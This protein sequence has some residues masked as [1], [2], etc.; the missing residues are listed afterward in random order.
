MNEKMKR[1]ARAGNNVAVLRMAY[2]FFSLGLQLCILFYA[3][4]RL[5]EY[6]IYFYA[7]CSGI[8]LVLSLFIV[9]NRSNPGYK[10]AWI[11]IVLTLPIFGIL[12]YLLFGK[13]YA[14]RRVQR[15][16][17]RAKNQVREALEQDCAQREGLLAENPEAE[18]QMRYLLHMESCPP[19]AGTRAEFLSPGGV[20]FA[21]M[22]EE[23]RK[24]ERFI[25]LE[26]FILSSG[27]MWDEILEILIEK[28]KAGVEVRVIY[29]DLG[30]LL[31]LPRHCGDFLRANGIA[32]CVFGKLVPVL[33]ALI[34]HRDHRKILVIDGKVGITGGINIAD[35]YINVKKKHGYW[36]DASI[37]LEGEAVWPLTCFFLSTW[38]Y[39]N[40]VT[41]DFHRYRAEQYSISESSGLYQP[42]YD[43]PLDGEQV[44]E[45]VY[46]NM[47]TRAKR[48]IYIET[49]YLVIDHE[50]TVAL[51]NAAKQGVD[52]RI[53]TP[54]IGDRWYV[55][56]VTRS[57]YGELIQSGIRIFEYTPGFIHAKVFICDD[58]TAS[59]G[60]VNL[61]YRS[62]YLHFECGVL[63]HKA[64]VLAD[65][66]ADFEE[67]L[68]VSQEISYAQ[69]KAVPW[70]RRMGRGIIR[71]F[72]PLL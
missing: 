22:K 24:A 35:E 72:A 45:N 11:L 30:S 29:D 47:I 40:N 27:Q 34:N 39:V 66:K 48:Y 56:A 33:S 68:A 50:M 5:E 17:L 15:R 51:C 62:L 69:C 4:W 32:H 71:V 18:N 25:F 23:L 55:Q 14:G 59:I 70:Y 60:T 31:S 36:K 7:I 13:E 53:V 61:D 16:L 64:P 26:Y 54:H 3:L 28:A 8:G 10:I 9:N 1:L 6:F 42:Y 52:V 41:E 37:L 63:L 65:M 12:L 21:R 20:K 2:I 19:Y 38:G 58:E 44:A 67:I 49:P 46:L 43:S 57:N